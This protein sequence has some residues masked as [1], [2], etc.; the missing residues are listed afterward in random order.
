MSIA[1]VTNF[2][3]SADRYYRFVKNI[4]LK[5]LLLLTAVC[6]VL[7]NTYNIRGFFNPVVWALPTLQ[8]VSY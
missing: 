6:A 1:I 2:Y 7:S 8:L 3:R 4:I 5:N